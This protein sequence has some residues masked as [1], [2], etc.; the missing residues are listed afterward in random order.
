MD[1]Q[2]SLGSAASSGGRRGGGNNRDNNNRRSNRGGGRGGGRGRGGG[3]NRNNS[4]RNNKKNH[5]VFSLDLKILN[6]GDGTTELQTS[7]MRRT[8]EYLLSLRLDYLDPPESFDP[9]VHCAWANEEERK[10]EIAKLAQAARQ[11][12]DVSN[13]RRKPKE[14]APPLEDCKPL[15]VNDET[16]WKSKVFDGKIEEEKDGELSDDEVMKKALLILNKLSLTKF[17]KLSNE[18]VDTGIG[19]NKTTLESAV[20]MIVEKA[21][22]E[23]HF[24]SMYARLCFK[25]SKSKT[26]SMDDGNRKMFKKL[27]LTRCQKE[28]LEDQSA[29]IDAAVKGITDEEEIAYK[30]GILKKSYLG[31]MRFIGELYKGDMI[32]LDI[33]LF[34]LKKCLEECEEEKVECF[35]KLMTTV[36]YPLEQQSTILAQTG[37]DNAKK[38]LDDCWKQVHDLSSG[39]KV[40]NRLK[41]M[42]QDLVEMRDKGWVK[43]REE[44]TAKTLDQIH[45]DVEREEK[46]AQ[47]SRRQS[48]SSRNLRRSTS[49]STQQKQQVDQDGFTAVMERP[50]SSNNLN[51]LTRS[52]SDATANK[53]TIRRAQSMNIM[54]NVTIMS[55][56]DRK[57]P[58]PSS[59]STESKILMRSKSMLVTGQTALV[60]ESIKESPTMSRKDVASKVESLVKEYFV[61]GDTKDALLSMKEILNTS[62]DNSDLDL[63][64]IVVESSVLFVLE[65]KREDVDKTLT[66]L[67]ASAEEL[68]SPEN[69]VNGLSDPLEFLSDIQ[70]DAPKASE[71]L[72]VMLSKLPIDLE[73]LLMNAPEYFR[74]DGKPA[75]LAAQ[76]LL[77]QQRPN[78][79][80]VSLVEKLMTSRDKED[81]ASA[82]AL[83]DSIKKK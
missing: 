39:K 12:G 55:N 14:T 50:R 47:S 4:N 15:E 28:F 41:F 23:P 76:T 8:S 35:T 62:V 24:S 46:Q 30:I 70:I 59:N 42:L 37:K 48:S 69:F 83:V 80:I 13:N 63:P 56:K 10:E 2:T 73:S 27:L 54:G 43:R 38:E 67:L 3:N 40:S 64:K 18:F 79:D 52:Q 25:L 74:T 75:Q 33:M 29:K 71:Y 68:L 7:V 17:D 53:K 57:Q 61:V 19:R 45:R 6:P 9:P 78:E 82:Q 44:E 26:T 81:F 22:S 16:R 58:V 77:E 60:S 32:K 11:G 36:G 1:R 65:R 20:A 66:L 51:S 72:A 34:C 49:M 31:H 5:E 21:Q